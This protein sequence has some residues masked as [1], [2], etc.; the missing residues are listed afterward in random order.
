MIG[1]TKGRS[2]PGPRT[3]RRAIAAIVVPIIGPSIQGSGMSIKYP[4]SPDSTPIV[5]ARPVS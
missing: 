2:L 4:I 3:G 5:N 1:M